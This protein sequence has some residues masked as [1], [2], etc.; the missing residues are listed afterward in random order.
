MLEMLA[1]GSSIINDNMRLLVLTKSVLVLPVVL[2]RSRDRM[3]VYINN[4]KLLDSSDFMFTPVARV[5]MPMF[6]KMLSEMANKFDC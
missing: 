5:A 4:V 3:I 2:E 1:A 6:F